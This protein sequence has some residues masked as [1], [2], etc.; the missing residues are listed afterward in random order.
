MITAIPHKEIFGLIIH[1]LSSLW[2][3][4]DDELMLIDVKLGG[5]LIN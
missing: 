1:Q 5:C 4:S 3:I 2:I